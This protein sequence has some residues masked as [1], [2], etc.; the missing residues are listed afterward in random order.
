MKEDLSFLFMHCSG[1]MPILF[2]VMVIVTYMLYVGP[3][4]LF[5]YVKCFTVT[6]ITK[7]LSI[8]QNC[9]PLLKTCVSDYAHLKVG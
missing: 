4:F 9:L 2:V 8:F 7:T 1:L 3:I 6:N 5:L